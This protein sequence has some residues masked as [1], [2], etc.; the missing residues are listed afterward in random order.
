M[1]SDADQD[2]LAARA[3][4]KL[5]AG[6]DPLDNVRWQGEV[7]AAADV[8][9][10][11]GDSAALLRGPQ[12]LVEPQGGGAHVLAPAAAFLLQ[13]RGLGLSAGFVV[14]KGLL[15]RLPVGLGVA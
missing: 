2:A 4:D 8:A 13:A 14:P 1:G 9:L 7:T 10:H 12:P 6:A 15:L 11:A 3:L 5:A